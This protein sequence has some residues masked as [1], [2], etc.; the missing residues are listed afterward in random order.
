VGQW[1]RMFEIAELQ[2]NDGWNS[3][4]GKA[5]GNISFCLYVF[6]LLVVAS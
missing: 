5:A 2:E 1:V 6:C 4:H 3:R